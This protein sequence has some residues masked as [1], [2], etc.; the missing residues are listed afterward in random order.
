MPSPRSYLM[1][2]LALYFLA[3]LVVV[4]VFIARSHSLFWFFDGSWQLDMMRSQAVWGGGPSV[5]NYDPV[6]GLFNFFPTGD[7]SASPVVFLA[8]KLVH[9]ANV[10]VAIFIGYASLVFA[11]S[12]I[13]CIS[14]QISLGIGVLSTLVTLSFATPLV[15]RWPTLIFPMFILAPHIFE[16]SIAFAFLVLSFALLSTD[17]MPRVMTVPLCLLAT[18]WSLYFLFIM[19]Q[20]SLLL[21]PPLMFALSILTILSHSKGELLAKLLLLSAVGLGAF[22]SGAVGFAVNLAGSTSTAFFWSEMPVYD[23]GLLLSS[24]LYQFAR[25]PF[26]ALLSVASGLGSACLWWMWRKKLRSDARVQLCAVNTLLTS[27]MWI[28]FPAIWVFNSFVLKV[29]FIY[30]VRLIY[31]EYVFYLF[32]SFFASCSLVFIISFLSK[33]VVRRHY[34][35][36]HIAHIICILVILVILGDFIQNPRLEGANAYPYPPQPS[37]ITTLLRSEIGVSPDTRFRGRV[38]TISNDQGQSRQ[39]G[40]EDSILEDIQEIKLTG[41]DHRFDGLWYFDIPTLQ[42]FSPFISPATYL[43]ETRFLS[44]PRTIHNT[45]NT[46]LLTRVNEMLFRLLGVRFLIIGNKN[47]AEI[48]VERARAGNRILYE[49]PDANTSGWAVRDVERVKDAS[50]VLN[51]MRAEANLKEIAYVTTG[52]QL[53]HLHPASTSMTVSPGVVK[54]AART[55]GKAFIVLPFQFSRCFRVRRESGVGSPPELFRTD[56]ALTG[57]LISEDSSF[58]IEMGIDLFNSA[59]CLREDAIELTNMK[60]VEAGKRFPLAEKLRDGLR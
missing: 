10:P 36:E 8:N 4:G 34:K 17:A 41:N 40:W 60:L 46:V 7:Y 52:E 26:G 2:R 20:F 58:V 29:P 14:L 3:C 6:R 50:E 9:S 18:V 31:F 23:G 55:S 25:F 30:S 28:L 32:T 45:R 59:R 15:W 11:L 27:G 54:I 1:S 38:A 5:W 39:F 35:I 12:C 33:I 49:I 19:P 42:E 13:A 24:M 16:C 56:L 21:L 57:V 37:A 44:G 22:L 51:K 43:L 48:G 53:E 47:K